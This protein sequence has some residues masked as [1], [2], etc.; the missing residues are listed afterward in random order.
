MPNNFT[1]NVKTIGLVAGYIISILCLCIVAINVGD[2]T[3]DEIVNLLAAIALGSA[4][5][6]GVLGVGEVISNFF[7]AK[8]QYQ[9]NSN[10]STP[11]TPPVSLTIQATSDAPKQES[12]GLT[13]AP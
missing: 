11:V 6:L 1:V 4:G 2:G 9:I 12:S 3:R 10:N 7:S 8:N 13:P 5:T